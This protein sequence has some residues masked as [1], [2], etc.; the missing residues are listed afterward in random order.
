MYYLVLSL[1]VIPAILVCIFFRNKGFMPILLLLTSVFA[2]IALLMGILCGITV[3]FIDVNGNIT[4]ERNCLPWSVV[5]Y[6][7]VRQKLK[8]NRIYVLNPYRHLLEMNT[9]YYTSHPIDT[10]MTEVLVLPHS[11]L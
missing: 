3:Y 7:G 10:T 9:I 5:E 6:A 2:F 4:K 8:F 1:I 11:T